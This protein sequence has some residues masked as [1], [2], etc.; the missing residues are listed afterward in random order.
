MQIQNT[1]IQ[2]F[3]QL[4]VWQEG[5]ELVL[6]VYKIVRDFPNE[7]KYA[8]GDQ[9]RRCSVSITSNIAEGFGRQGKKE[10]IQFYYTSQA[11]NIELQNQLLIAHD[12][13][14]INK[15]AFDDLTTKSISV[16]KQLNA[17]IRSIKSKHE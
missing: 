14:Y 5:H 13:G 10:K 17:L 6:L 11:S 16:A 12:V 2:T 3:T 4:R 9:M 8:L 1:K 7:E 15:R